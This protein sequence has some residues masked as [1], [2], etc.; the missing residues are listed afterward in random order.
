MQTSSLKSLKQEL[1][2]LANPT[3]AKLLQR[4]FKTKAG[5]Y[6]EGDI[7]LGIKVPEQRK[8]AKS[9]CERLKIEDLQEL[10]NSNIHEKRLI[11][12]MCLIERYKTADKNQKKEI[13]DFYLKNAKAGRIN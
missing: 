3:Q 2:S 1:S 4:F 10:L 11:A 5:E 12:L 9:C 13:F 7:F 8:I 6:G